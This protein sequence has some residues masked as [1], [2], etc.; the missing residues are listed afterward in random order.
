[1]SGIFSLIGLAISIYLWLKINNTKLAVGVF[2]FFL[3]EF[4]Q[5]WQYIWINDCESKINQILTLLGYIHICYQPYFCQLL[6]AA[7]TKNTKLLEQYKIVHKLCLLGGTMLLSRYLLY[8]L[9][10]GW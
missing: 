10:D 9:V 5:F 6:N 1:M 7:L 2:W 3:M 8:G 4:L